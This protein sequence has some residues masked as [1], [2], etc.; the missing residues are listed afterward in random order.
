MILLLLGATGA[1][2]LDHFRVYPNAPGFGADGPIV[3]IDDQF[4]ALTTDL[5]LPTRFMVPVDKNGEG[6]FDFFSHLT[7][8]QINDGTAG[9]AVISTNQFGAQPLTLGAPDSLCVPT[10][11]LISPGPVS[12]DHYKCYLASG[13]SVGIG[14]LL[15][16]QFGSD[17][18]IVLSPLLFCTPAAKNGEPIVDPVTHLTCYD[19]VP[20]SVTPGPI[21]TLNQFSASPE[22]LSLLGAES[23]CV[24][25]TK[26]LVSPV[27]APSFTA[28]GLGSLVLSMMGVSLLL[29]RRQR[30]R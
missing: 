7:C 23:L 13:T 11:N 20:N 29:L 22:V 14:V 19:T 28:V 1:N 24:P 18:V 9:P 10:E 30:S 8:Y 25:S 26:Q 5:G 16:D 17:S 3:Q 12:V 4:G 21:P 27:A 6:L 15:Q 2:A